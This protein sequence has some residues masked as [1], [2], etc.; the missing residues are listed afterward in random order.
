MR[1]STIALVAVLAAGTAHAQHAHQADAWDYRV[2]ALVPA[3]TKEQIATGRAQR[4]MEGEL[5]AIPY[6]VQNERL[7]RELSPGVQNWHVA[8]PGPPTK[9]IAAES[10]T[11]W[12]TEQVHQ[13][14]SFVSPQPFAEMSPAPTAGGAS[15]FQ[16]QQITV[17]RTQSITHQYKGGS[18]QQRQR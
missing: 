18:N 6:W 7:K 4:G 11:V 10:V 15:D 8:P 16:G 2:P 12:R 5:P 3:P 9:S 1:T 14:P 13:P 17:W